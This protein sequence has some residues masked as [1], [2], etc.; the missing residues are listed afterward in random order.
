MLRSVLALTFVATT[1]ASAQF[2]LQD[3]HTTADLRGID[4]VG[5]GVA[6]ASGTDG[7]ILR[8]EDAGFVWQL[9]AKPPGGEHL[10]FRAIQAFDNN[11]A[12]VMS[13]G[14]GDLSRLYKTTDGCQSWKLLFTNPDKDGFWDA[15]KFPNRNL[16]FILGDPVTYPKSKEAGQTTPFTG[17]AVFATED[18]GVH[19]TRRAHEGNKAD[20]TANGAFAASNS[21]LFVGWPFIYFGTGGTA[22]AHVF[23]NA[24]QQHIGF[25]DE[26]I[27]IDS[28]EW[29]S[30]SWPVPLASGQSA[31]VFSIAFLREE[32]AR[33]AD[34]DTSAL[35]TLFGIAVGGDYTKPNEAPG[36][37]AFTA[38]GGQ[39]WTAA[40]TPPHGYRSAVAYDP[41]TKTWITVGPN[42][43][44]I[45][46]D[47]GR[48]WRPLHPD[49]RF[50]D[51]PDADQH[52]NALSLPYV[53]GPHGRIGTLRS[54]ALQPAK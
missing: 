50:N 12:I 26:H 23:L 34:Y 36:T 8:T 37:A 28:G 45:S 1:I 49:P 42:G 52:W 14:K 53:V 4:N 10:D 40:T 44:D 15:M 13:S 54:S 3:A 2:T 24:F 38:D 32:Q 35:P 39:H 47:D 33:N 11:T 21:S 9:C 22:G 7:T 20:P 48:N 19:F 5:G 17:F 29:R 43:T 25:K 27:D 30:R 18:G 51:A 41:T 31:G 46:T 6:W 16:G